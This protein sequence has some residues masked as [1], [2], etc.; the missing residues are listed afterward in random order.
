MVMVSERD[1]DEGVSRDFLLHLDL[2]L[3]HIHHSGLSLGQVRGLDKQ[4]S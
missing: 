4:V 1:T 2:A 3:T